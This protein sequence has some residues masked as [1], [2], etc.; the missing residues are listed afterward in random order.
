M[1]V[2]VVVDEHSQDV[3]NAVTSE[4]LRATLLP[5]GDAH[6]LLDQPEFREDLLPSM[7]RSAER[8]ASNKMPAT[9]DLA[10]KQMAS[11]LQH[12]ISRL[13]ELQKVNRSVRAEEIEML[14]EQQRA[15]DEHLSA[16]RL[17]LD[18]LRVIYCRRGL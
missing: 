11:Q 1:P 14:I 7:I 9:I 8:I 4:S 15:L 2:R 10:K 5:L 16:S 18:A 6:P 17:R 3:G 13:K 12:E